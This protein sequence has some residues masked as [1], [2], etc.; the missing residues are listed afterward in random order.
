ML[1]SFDFLTDNEHSFK[2]LVIDTGNGGE[3][4][5]HNYI[6]RRDYGG[7]YDKW[8]FLS[9]MQGF[10]TSIPEWQVMLAKLDKLRQ[11]RKMRIVMLCHTRIK[12][13]K[14]PLGQNFDRY[15]PAMHEK[16]WEVTHRWADV[17]LFGNFYTA[18]QTEG[19]RAKGVGGRQRI[20]YTTKDAAYDAGNRLSLPEEIDC[21]NSAA[22]AWK[23]FTDAVKAA[24]GV[25]Q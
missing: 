17:I 6:C 1:D 2:Q 24:K 8:G 25:Q 19:N 13:F 7:K 15:I 18:V 20:I 4:L 12:E 21:G 10:E 14:N 11:V 9:Y 16:T 3:K 5:L 23:N 22:E